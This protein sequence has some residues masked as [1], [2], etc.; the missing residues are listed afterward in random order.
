MKGVGEEGAAFNRGEE[1]VRRKPIH[2]LVR[3]RRTLWAAT[4]THIVA[5]I[6]LVGA[7]L[8]VANAPSFIGQTNRTALFP[9]ETAGKTLALR[10]QSPIPGGP[11]GTY[12]TTGDLVGGDSLGSWV[13]L[14]PSI[15][16]PGDLD[17]PLMADYGNRSILL[18]GGR[19]CTALA[20]TPD[21]CGQEYLAQATWEFTGD[22]W[23]NISAAVGAPSPSCA[24]PQGGALVYDSAAGYD[25]LW[26]A[27]GNSLG[28][29]QYVLYPSTWEFDSSGW[30]NVTADGPQPHG[31]VSMAF[32]SNLTNAAVVAVTENGSTWSFHGGKWTD[33]S[34]V[35]PDFLGDNPSMAFDPSTG[36]LILAGAGLDT[37]ST[38]MYAGGRWTNVTGPP[39]LS[40]GPSAGMLGWYQQLPLVWDP[41]IGAIITYGVPASG[42]YQNGTTWAWLNESWVNVTGPVGPSAP[43]SSEAADFLVGALLGPTGALL[44]LDPSAPPLVN[45]GSVWALTVGPI[46]FLRAAPAVPEA[47]A[48]LSLDTVVYGG[49]G[50]FQFQYDGLPPGCPNAGGSTLVCEPTAPGTFDAAVTVTDAARESGTA[51]LLIFVASRLNATFDAAPALLD[52]GENWN[53]TIVVEGGEAP[54]RFNYSGL[55]PHCQVEVSAIT[56]VA[57]PPGRYPVSATVVDAAGVRATWNETLTVNPSLSISVTAVPR[58]GEVG[59]SETL[60]V[61]EAGGTPPYTVQWSNLPP[62]CAAADGVADLTCTPSAAGTFAVSVRTIDSTGGSARAST[63][64]VEQPRLTLVAFS[65]VPSAS[66]TVG[67]RI[68]L[69]TYVSGGVLP[70]RYVYLGLPSGC[71]SANTSNLSCAPGSGSWRAE[72]QV[73]DG[74]GVAV[75]GNVSLSVQPVAGLPAWAYFAVL[76]AGTLGALMAALWL[77]RRR[78]GSAGPGSPGTLQ[79]GAW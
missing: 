55:P 26:T 73:V 15:Q 10:P 13:N 52:A 42:S 18:V 41:E 54:Y 35:L 20:L 39:S 62:G 75:T 47:G 49:T 65:V 5:S 63:E 74:I 40:G 56:C 61:T 72:V 27:Y 22:Q 51:A 7:L 58:M 77:R 33:L 29:Y 57:I 4:G 50:P 16:P 76:G 24:V 11:T 19:G 34:V 71:A 9:A 69:E 17:A 21:G 6:L 45:P 23:Q 60:Q 37:N 70:Y 31:V 43:P 64:L 30:K 12:E 32:D 3:R 79:S 44:V 38:W 46:P 14:T 48:A 2:E 8:P 66:V 53:L 1:C 78:A 28:E 59:V 68:L 36:A 67:Q 25:V